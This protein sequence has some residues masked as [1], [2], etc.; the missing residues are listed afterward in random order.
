[1]RRSAWEKSISANPAFESLDG[2][3]WSPHFLRG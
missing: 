2:C 1:V 3:L